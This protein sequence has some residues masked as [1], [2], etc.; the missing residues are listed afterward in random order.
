MQ[1]ISKLNHHS[2][3]LAVNKLMCINPILSAALHYM[4]RDRSVENHYAFF[5]KLYVESGE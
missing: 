5:K 3:A 1:Y 2:A 4:E